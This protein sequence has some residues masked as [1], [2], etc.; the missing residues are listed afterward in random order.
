[1]NYD[2]LVNEAF[3]QYQSV[4]ALSRSPLAASD[5]VTPALVLD[6]VTPTAE[7]RGRGLRIVL[8]W[9]VAQLAPAAPPHPLGASRPLDDPTWRDPRWWRYNILRHRYLE[10]LH[11]DDFV[12]GG[13]FTETLL[14]LTGIPSPDVFFGERNRGVRMVAELLARQEAGRSADDELRR[15]AVAA[16]CQPLAAQPAAHK[17]LTIAALFDDVFPRDLLLALAASEGISAAP[18]ALAWLVEQRYL[19]AGDAGA[20]LWLGPALRAHFRAEQPAADLRRRHVRVAEDLARR[21]ELLAAAHHYQAA[22]HWAAA[23]DLIL[24]IAAQPGG[25]WTPAQLRPLLAAFPAS[26]PDA[27]RRRR[28][29]LLRADT[30]AALGEIDAAIDAARAGLAHAPTAGERVEFQRRL[31]KFYEKR[32]PLHALAYYGQAEAALAPDDPALPMLLK[33]R[34]WLHILQRDWGQAEADLTHGLALVRSDQPTLRAD[35]LDALASLRRNQ[36]EFA[37]AIVCAQEALALREATGDLLAVAKSLGNLGLHYTAAGAYDDAVAA[38]REAMVTYR[39]LGHQEMVATAWLNIVAAPCW[40]QG[41]EAARRHRFDDQVRYFVELATLYPQLNASTTAAAATDLPAAAMPMPAASALSPTAARMVALA[42]QHGALT[43]RLLMQALGI[44]KPTATRRLRDLTNAG[45]LAA[46]GKGRAT[47]YAAVAGATTGEMALNAELAT[48]AAEL[49]G[50][51]GMTALYVVRIAADA[52]DLAVHFQ[53][54]PDLAAFFRLERRLAA[55][56]GGPVHLKPDTE[57]DEEARRGLLL[58]WV[59]GG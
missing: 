49:V 44:S 9:A 21:G 5:L 42:Q 28:L 39:R 41:M 23:A 26:Q 46:H 20:Q 4:L 52:V 7:E 35:L 15:L 47:C 22:E 30:H 12:E 55:G 25:E 53:Q 11:P 58:V 31:G 45:L 19:L 48:L 16:A 29:H 14:A 54:L 40:Q 32:N 34:G 38:H 17:L 24:Q 3:K 33:D 1:M 18:T 36:R 13:R 56:L 8:Q 57:L 50:E 6:D 10:P 27:A 59:A 43:P 37:V 51:Y 2:L